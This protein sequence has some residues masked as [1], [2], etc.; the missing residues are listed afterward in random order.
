[1][2]TYA[3]KHLKKRHTLLKAF[4][5]AFRGLRN[6]F[7]A[8]RNGKIQ[9]LIACLTATFACAFHISSL[10]WI[11]VLLCIAMALALEMFNSAIEKLCDFVNK[12]FH[13]AI[14][15]IKDVSA[16]GVLWASIMSIVIGCI[17]FIPKIISLL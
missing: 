3:S 5:C 17:I 6:F 8:E 7:L 1:M 15:I 12:D 16:A 10:E 14:K 11:A 13:P 2:V 4:Y 9:L